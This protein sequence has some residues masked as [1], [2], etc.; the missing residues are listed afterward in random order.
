MISEGDC[1]PAI[2]DPTAKPADRS[3]GCAACSSPWTA[4]DRQLPQF[5]LSSTTTQ[6]CCGATYHAGGRSCATVPARPALVTR[7]APGTLLRQSRLHQVF[8]SS[9]RTL[10]LSPQNAAQLVP[11]RAIQLLQ[12]PHG[13]G[14]PEP[15]ASGRRVWAPGLA[16][17]VR[18]PDLP[19]GGCTPRPVARPC[20]SASAAR[21]AL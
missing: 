7:G 12:R 16:A 14:Q 1:P 19:V 17:S 9:T 13:L 2:S 10:P 5:R 18:P 20:W 8:G 15:W 4:K 3:A 6:D 21:G 11:D